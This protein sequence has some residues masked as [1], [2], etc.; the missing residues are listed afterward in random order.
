M[1]PVKGA[2]DQLKQTNEIKV[3]IP[4]L[5][6]CRLD[7]KDK[8]ITVD[9]LLT[10]RSLATWLRSGQAHYHFTVKGNQPTLL[11]DL[12]QYFLA[13]REPA[14]THTCAGHGRIETRCIWVT[15]ALNGYLEFPHVHQAF[16]IQ[17]QVIEKKTGKT[18]CELAYGITSRPASEASPQRLLQ[19]NRG[20][21]TIE[22]RC[23]YIIDWTYD[24]DRGRIRTGHGPENITRLRRFAVALILCKPGRR[25]AETM[26]RL[27]RNVRTVFDY[28]LMSENSRRTPAPAPA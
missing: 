20:H 27:N 21:W 14:Y 6:S 9:A 28:L 17:R 1:L 10:Q 12:Q 15:E 22:N 13:R 11:A 26:R 2:A 24:E 18:S 5:H 8:D 3:A 25:A 19:I 23:H 7:L 4:L 16:L